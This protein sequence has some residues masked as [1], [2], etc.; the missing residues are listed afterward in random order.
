MDKDEEMTSAHYEQIGEIIREKYENYNPEL[1][2]FIFE[3]EGKRTYHYYDKKLIGHSKF[4]IDENNN[5]KGI[6]F[7]YN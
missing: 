6:F 5:I 4:D 1:Y 3:L 2:N 7:D